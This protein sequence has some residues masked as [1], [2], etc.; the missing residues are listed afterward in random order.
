MIDLTMNNVCRSESHLRC[1]TRSVTG[2]FCKRNPGYYAQI[3]ARERAAAKRGAEIQLATMA[4]L[5]AAGG[6]PA[7]RPIAPTDAT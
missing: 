2:K 3:K 7:T 4:P 1:L 5:L 6:D